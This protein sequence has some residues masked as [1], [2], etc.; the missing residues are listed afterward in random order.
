[1]ATEVATPPGWT[2]AGCEVMADFGPAIDDDAVG[3][4]EVDA[5]RSSISRRL[6][7][8]AMSRDAGVLS[9]LSMDSPGAFTEM[10]DSIESFR[11]H[12]KAIAEM[13]E[14]AWIRMKIADRRVGARNWP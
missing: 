8:L 1:M 13:A 6:A 14:A 3:R 9:R 12:A 11:D 2:D 10:I 4:I 7:L 5:Q